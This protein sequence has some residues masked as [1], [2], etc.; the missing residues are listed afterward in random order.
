MVRA[1]PL[2][3]TFGCCLRSAFTMI[4]LIFAIVLIAVVTLT[5]P[6]M[7]QV[8]NKALEG[9][10]A[11]EAIFL[12]SAILSETTT[13]VWDNAALDSSSG[14]IVTSKILDRAD[15]PLVYV[16]GT[17][18]TY[19]GR[20]DFNSTIR[21]G[22]LEQDMHRRF[23]DLNST[24]NGTKPVGTAITVSLANPTADLTGAGY[25]SDFNVTASRVY[26]ADTPS[27]VALGVATFNF[28]TASTG[29]SNIKMTE[30]VI[31]KPVSDTNATLIDVAR[32]RAY[33]TNIGE[34]DYAK[35]RL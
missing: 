8:N 35:R 18:S 34:I 27:A 31:Q 1:K 21:I 30:V 19:Y 13:Y 7:I 6:T 32:L 33:T 5:I 12:V 22:G 29:I 17:P 24:G 23:F 11:Q 4:E 10:I 16:A 9:S 20:R 25:K 28:T 3:H 14:D 15:V 2:R 26:I